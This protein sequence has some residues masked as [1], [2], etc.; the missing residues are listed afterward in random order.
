MNEE[1]IISAHK[2]VDFYQSMR[3]KIHEFL[4][5]DEGRKFKFTEYLLLV[6]DMFHLLCKLS[7]DKDVKTA[8]K[9]KLAGVIAYFVLPIDVVPDFFPGVGYLD[10][11]ALAAYALNAVLNHT[12]SAVVEKHWAGEKNILAAIKQILAVADEMIGA[13]LFKKVKDFFNNQSENS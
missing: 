2:K 4:E 9:A 8:D 12:D 5:T 3:Q 7:L 10:D 13:G 1:I 11:L 6:P